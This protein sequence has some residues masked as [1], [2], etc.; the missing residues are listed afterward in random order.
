MKF[1]R[2][3]Y[4][5]IVLV[6]YAIF[7]VWVMFIYSFG[8]HETRPNPK[9][10]AY[11]KK[12]LQQIVKIIGLDVQVK[13]K[14]ESTNSDL[15]GNRQ[16]ALWVANHISWM[17][18]AIAGSQGVAFLSKKEIRKWPIIGWL[19]AQSGTVFIDRGS[20]NASENAAK[21][22]ADKISSGD[23]ILVFPEG[24][25]GSGENV[26][27]FHAR[28]FAPAL[29]HQLLVQPIAVQYLDEHGQPHTKATWSDQSFI[30]NLMGILAEPSLHVV[31]T[32]LPVVDAKE[33]N[34]RR[35]LAELVENQIRDIVVFENAIK[36]A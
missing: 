4:K 15:K 7:A 32:F 13:G 1:F 6:L 3:T 20:K 28:I 19:A 27:R 12:W 18:I 24:T 14:V 5:L 11:R 29:D 25:T 30:S 22:I 26:K 17:D 23:S 10:R 2:I 33:F 16:S 35:Q 36:I 21:S 8:E 34:G 31:L 9:Q